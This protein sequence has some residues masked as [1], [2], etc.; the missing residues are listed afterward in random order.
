M[1]VF[2]NT[3]RLSGGC[4]RKIEIEER[5]YSEK[6]LILLIDPPLGVC[7][8]RQAENVAGSDWEILEYKKDPMNPGA[9][10]VYVFS[11]GKIH[12]F[13]FHI[14]KT[15]Y[16]TYKADVFFKPIPN[17]EIEKST[18]ILPN[19]HDATNLFK[20]TMTESTYN[21]QISSVDSILH[22]SK[23]LGLYETEVSSIDRAIMDLG[24]IVRFDD[25][26]VGALGKCLKNGFTTKDLIKVEKEAYLK[27]FDMDVVYLLH[28]STNSYEFFAI[29]TTWDSN[30]TMLILKPSSGAQEL[31][32]NIS[33][34]Y[35]EV[36]EAKKSKLSKL[37]NF[38]DYMP[39]MT[40]DT[41]YFNNPSTL[42]KKLNSVF[43]KF[44]ESRSN[45]ALLSIQSPYCNKVLD[46]LEAAS[47]FPTIKL[48]VG[49][50]SL[51]AV[52]WQSLIAK[53]IVN[54]YFSLASWLKNM[55]SLSSYG[56][57]PLCNLQIE[58]P[59]YLIDIEYSRRLTQNNVVLWWSNKPY[60]DHGGFQNDH[61]QDFDNFDF[62]TINSPE[63]Y[64]TAC[65]EVEIG[66]LTINTIL[67]S[68]LINEAEGTDLS[69]DP[70]LGDANNGAS[71]LALDTFSPVALGILRSMVKDWWD[72]AVSNN[73][74]ADSMMNSLVSWV[75]RQ[76]S[77]LYDF[78][79]HHHIHNLTSKALLQL[80]GEF[81]RMNANV[82][83]A[84]R[85][86]LI[87]QTTKISVENSYAFG[88]YVVNA[89]RSKPLFNFLDLKIVR[90]WDILVWMDEFNFAG[91]C[92]TEITND[93]V[94]Q[95]LPVSKWHIK[96]FLPIIFQ[97]DFDD[98]LVI[99]L[100]AL[101]KYKN[102][103]LLGST[104][105]GTQ[106]V[107]QLAHI[108][109]GQQKMDSNDAEEEDQFT[110]EVMNNFRKPLQRRIE[111]LYRRQNESILNPEMAKEYEFPTLPGSVLKMK[112]PVLELVKFLC[113]VFALSKKRSI[114]VRMLRKDLLSVMDVKEFSPESIFS[115]PSAS[116]K[117]SSVICDYCS[118][119]RDI[120][121]CREEEKNIWTCTHCHHV[122]NKVFLEEELIAQ[123]HRN[124]SKYLTQDYTCQR[125]HAVKADNMSEFCKC[126]GAWVETLKFDDFSKRVNIFRNVA[127]AYGMKM[128]LGLI[129]DYF[130]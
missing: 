37:Y 6:T 49:E 80:V 113:A 93:D 117:V 2:C 23:I 29:F 62:I 108:L 1:S 61:V 104:Q 3:R 9:V 56:K 32:D 17:C 44:H 31:P 75:Q 98:W 128:L 70:L 100:D 63:I 15:I 55:T 60:P 91:R 121:F 111:K 127:K 95:L 102:E 71:T 123:L 69:D 64:E 106:R 43:R 20:M 21:E 14:P 85:S 5:N 36:Y 112:N 40:F 107:T 83:F 129:D 35:K 130:I 53:R 77:L 114:E 103:T 72:D 79:L 39:E 94:Q 8:R 13:L 88:K 119:I 24:N 59:G 96:K 67:T 4:N 51:P 118:F 57:V 81:R 52:G 78:T 25:T 50:I 33:K 48:S 124:I 65:L 68:S 27:K 34:I 10:K 66:N 116:L 101:A 73:A 126:S 11:G 89:T 90:Y 38:I 7:F 82:V 26:K 46:L 45:K 105:K 30:V 125:C 87:I 47:D 109:K 28:I 99:F 58:T 16:A 74:N 41:S 12:S 86:K 19:G 42:Y 115:S 84:N 120:D 122:Y 18:A 76:D 97:N 110:G 22:D 92:C 54:H